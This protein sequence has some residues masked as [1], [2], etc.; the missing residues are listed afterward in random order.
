VLGEKLTY[1]FKR[2]KTHTKRRR[3]SFVDD[4]ASAPLLAE[5]AMSSSD[6]IA[7]KT[8]PTSYAEIFT[9]QTSINLLSYTFLALHA[10]AYDQVLPVFLNYPR[11]NPDDPNVHLP[12]KFTGGFGLSSDK[13]G[14]IYTIYGIAC[15]IVQFF[16]FPPL[17]A[18]FGVLN[19]YR[20]ASTSSPSPPP[21]LPIHNNP[22]LTNPPPK[23]RAYS[24]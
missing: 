24:P 9:R 1:T 15:G 2:A 7:I 5:S 17:C 22:Q 14:T 20:V 8:E 16:L 23:Q 19:C 18:R 11:I 4:E 21:S 10:V 6:E 3:L 13:I 12:F